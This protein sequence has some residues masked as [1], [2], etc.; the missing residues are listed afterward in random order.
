MDQV[1]YNLR[2]RWFD[3]LNPEDPSDIRPQSPI[4]RS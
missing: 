3:I 2:F 1:D 4:P